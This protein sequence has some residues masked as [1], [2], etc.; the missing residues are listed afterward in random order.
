MSAKDLYHT[1]VIHALVKD[2]WVITHDPYTLSFG[3]KNVFIDIGAERVLAA[4]R[5][6]EKIA[7]EVKSFQ[8]PSDLR[9]LEMALGQ[10][11]LYRSLLVR[12]E[13]ERS[14]FLA[15]PHLVYFNTLDEPIARPVIEDA[16]IK[17]L[18]FDPVEERIVRW[19]P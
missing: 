18:L 8:G 16:V 11:V 5:N 1:A 2:G 14:L 15:V 6:E 13:P 4:E 19:I 17:L 12:V 10:Y 3:K 7:V 9:D